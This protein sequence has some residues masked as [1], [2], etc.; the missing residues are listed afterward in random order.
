[1]RHRQ[2]SGGWRQPWRRIAAASGL[3]GAS[4]SAASALWRSGAK[5]LYNV[6]AS[7]SSYGGAR[8]LEGGEKLAREEIS[9]RWRKLLLALTASQQRKRC[10]L[11]EI[12]AEEEMLKAKS[13]GSWRLAFCGG[14][15]A[16]AK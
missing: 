3:G 8:Q 11:R 9:R 10:P 15:L 4:A 5:A 16:P 12:T 6:S 14:W 13:Y 2:P 7:C 1:M